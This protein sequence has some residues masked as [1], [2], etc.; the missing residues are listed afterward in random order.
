MSTPTEPNKAKQ[1]G[2]CLM[3]QSRPDQE[4]IKN[5]IEDNLAL[6]KIVD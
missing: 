6:S 1:K 2:A 5:H 3:Q 4:E